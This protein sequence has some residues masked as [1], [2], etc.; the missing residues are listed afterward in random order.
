MS[1]QILKCRACNRYAGKAFVNPATTTADYAAI[2]IL[3]E[4]SITGHQHKK[5]IE[6][7]PCELK[8]ARFDIYLCIR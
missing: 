7:L 3:C 2:V 1:L 6:Y 5:L 4:L 8:C